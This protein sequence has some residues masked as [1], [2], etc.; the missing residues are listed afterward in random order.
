MLTGFGT[1]LCDL[2]TQPLVLTSPAGVPFAIGLPPASC[3][4]VG[5]QISTQALSWDGG[6]P[7]LTNALDVTIGSY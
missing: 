7:R 2:S 1:L 3:A 4:T 6:V 5:K